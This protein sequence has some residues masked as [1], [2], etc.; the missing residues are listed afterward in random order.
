[1]AKSKKKN[2]SA[3]KSAVRKPRSATKLHVRKAKPKNSA[4]EKKTARRSAKT[5]LEGT[6]SPAAVLLGLNHREKSWIR[7]F[8]NKNKSCFS[9]A[10]RS[11]I[12]WLAWPRALFDRALKAAKLPR[13][14]CTRPMP[15]QTR[16]IAISR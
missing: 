12:Q 9:F 15:D 7:L 13:S 1:M 3:A 16:T 11:W 5:N 10:M 8:A 4:G 6:Q 2:R 14:E